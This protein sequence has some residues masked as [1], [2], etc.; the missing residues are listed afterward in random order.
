MAKEKTKKMV[1]EIAWEV[2]NKVGGI[3][4]VLSSKA[5]EMTEE[6][7]DS[8]FLIGPYFAEKT[9]GEFEEKP[10]PEILKN[11]FAEL[12]KEDGLRFHFGKWLIKGEPQVIL[13][14]FKDFWQKANQIKTD[15]WNDFQIDSLAAGEDFTE[16]VV[17]STAAGKL[18]QKIAET[19][20]KEKIAA[21]FH[22]WLAGAG[23]L[24][25]KKNK[26]R[27]KTIFTTH[28]T[29]LGRTLAY[30]NIEFYNFIKDID[31]Q[32]EAARLNVTAK[33]LLEKST[34]VNCDI[35]TTVSEITALEAEYFL[36]RKPELIL[37]N[38]LNEEQF[39]S[40]EE[41]MIEH[42]IHRNRLRNFLLF[43]FFPYYSFDLE[44]TL[45]FFTASRYEVRAKGIDIFIKSLG[46][47]NKK[48]RQE[49]TKKTIVAFL[50]VPAQA[51]AIK[52]EILESR[53]F[54]NDIKNSLEEVAEQTEERMLYIMARGKEITEETL[55][56]KDFIFEIEKK[57]LKLK[58][59][60]NPPLSTH[61]LM[62]NQDVILKLL[63]EAGLDNKPDDKVKVV[64]YPIYLTGHDGLANLTYEEFLKA[65]HLG[66]FPS[67]YEPWGYTPLE[68]AGFGAPSITTDLTGFGR[69]LD[70]MKQKKYPGIF[71]IKRDQQKDEQVIG[72]LTQTMFDF[73]L[74]SRQERVENK[75]SAKNI[76]HEFGWKKLAKNYFKARELA[77]TGKLS[78]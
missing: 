40:F 25:L 12:E 56:N 49:K 65:S 39:P 78:F 27:I 7:K 23:L 69:A 10:A 54:L 1:F 42:K 9:K 26:S 51:R 43:Y 55:F 32:K 62:D 11:I 33:H 58:R 41:L 16:P 34:A 76:S 35:F 52:T 48:M 17:W 64:F 63:V 44:Q 74:Y 66:V 73:S 47:L 71:V 20:G 36:Q 31:P 2:V 15:L 30:N 18:L 21:H 67:F 77:L 50:L 28:A 37:P 57:F 38:G 14:D 61:D 46:E 8:Y 45:F 68:T 3:Y 75:I 70:K 6:Y 59:K 5:Q 29:S 22:E 60:G 72:D 19:T 13:I 4:T 53:E 24:F